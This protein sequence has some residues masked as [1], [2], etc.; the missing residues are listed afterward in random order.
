MFINDGK[1]NLLSTRYYIRLLHL[2]HNHIKSTS[3]T[4]EMVG[5]SLRFNRI[6]LSMDDNEY[7][8][9]HFLTKIHRI[10]FGTVTPLI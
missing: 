3:K 10:R 8:F 6:R 4:K 7:V 9:H 2:T 1:F 5:T